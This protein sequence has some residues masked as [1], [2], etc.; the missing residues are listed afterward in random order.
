MALTGIWISC[1]FLF[2][3]LGLDLFHRLPLALSNLP[4]AFTATIQALVAVLAVCSVTFSIE[5][6]KARRILALGMAFVIVAILILIDLSL[7]PS[8]LGEPNPPPTIP[9]HITKA[10]NAPFCDQSSGWIVSKPV[11]AGT[12]WSCT[13]QGLQL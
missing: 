4:N 11:K 2:A 1:F 8:A 10:W 3:L 9:V 12:S 13:H 5:L 7:P 6:K